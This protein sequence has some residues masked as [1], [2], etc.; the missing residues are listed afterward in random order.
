MSKEELRAAPAQSAP[1]KQLGGGKSLRYSNLELMR[2][3]AML[4]IIAHHY[5]VNS[6]L[7]AEMDFSA[8]TLRMFAFQCFGFGGKTAI[9][10]FVLLSAYFMC[11]KTLTWMRVGKLVC[12]VYFY[13]IIIGA[14]FFVLGTPFNWLELRRLVAG[15]LLWNR[16][17]TASFIVFYLTVPFLNRMVRSLTRRQHLRLVMLLVTVFTLVSTFLL[18]AEAWCYLGWYVTLYF[19]ASYIRFYPCPLTERWQPSAA[20]LALTLV[21]VACNVALA[22]WLGREQMWQWGYNDSQKLL[23]LSGGL[24]MFLLFKNVP[25]G[26]SRVVNTLS[27]SAFGVLLIHANCDAMRHW[28]WRDLL[29]NAQAYHTQWAVLHFA[30]SVAAVYV[31]CTAIDWLR[32][33][34]VE[35]PIVRAL[36]NVGW[37]QRECFMQ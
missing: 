37:L 9:N 34:L 36:R 10:A 25:M 3:C 29:N 2:I 8:P 7:V 35:R 5:V 6:G 15:P 19:I 14:V 24:S 16:G 30:V 32:I 18:Y 20:V 21:G 17:F 28:L 4:L 13:N 31:A 11:A 23:A 26:Y 12:E 27:A 33:R 22:D 1:A